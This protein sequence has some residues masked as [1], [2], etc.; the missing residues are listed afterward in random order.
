MKI[1]IIG[2]AYNAVDSVE[3]TLS[4]WLN[5]RDE[6]LGGNEFIIHAVS[7]PFAE[8]KNIP[9]FV[10]DHDTYRMLETL[11]V[12][13][14]IDYLT[15]SPLYMTE[16][17]SRSAG[18]VPLLIENCDIIWCVDLQDEY[19]TKK[20]ISEII[21]FVNLNKWTSWFTCNFRNYVFDERHYLEEFFTPP[22]IFRV[23][24]NGYILQKFYFD[25]DIT[26]KEELRESK[27]TSYK[28]LP[29]MNLPKNIFIKHLTWLNN[30]NSKKKI[31]YQKAR[32][33]IC[34]YTWDENLDCLDFNLEYYKKTNQSFPVVIE[35]NEE[36]K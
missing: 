16:A 30:E 27:E 28:T 33:W 25:N 34:S 9:G 22:R 23:K 15:I 32:G 4:P 36:K 17:E 35:E 8:Y 13:E 29:S 26:Y 5:A 20:I 2:M 14:K 6:K 12:Y 24:T 11:L 1:G 31:L 18:L 21:N 19:Y 3:K 10:E 7:V